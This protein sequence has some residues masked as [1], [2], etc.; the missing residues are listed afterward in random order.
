MKVLVATLGVLLPLGLT[1]GA[2]QTPGSRGTTTPS[3]FSPHTF[4][5]VPTI[6]ENSIGAD[7]LRA[8]SARRTAARWL[9]SVW[10]ASARLQRSIV[11]QLRDIVA[12][13]RAGA[14][15]LQ[16]GV[17]SNPARVEDVAGLSLDERDLENLRRC[18]PGD[19][20]LQLS[21]EALER[22]RTKY[23]LGQY[24]RQGSCRS[25]DAPGARRARQ[26][27]P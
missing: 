7:R 18:R 27:I 22:F 9:S 3:S 4:N 6:S 17:F 11:D 15:V 24:R 26:S 8:P 10:S 2:G 20:K 12:F 25:N 5:L 23:S 21:A 19:C 16:I 13:K 14:A 1:G